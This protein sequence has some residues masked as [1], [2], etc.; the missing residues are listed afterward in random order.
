MYVPFSLN[1]FCISVGRENV[2]GKRKQSETRTK[3]R[4]LTLTISHNIVGHCYTHS[5]TK[6]DKEIRIKRR[7][8]THRFTDKI[9]ELWDRQ[10]QR[11]RETW[12]KRRTRTHITCD[13][14]AEHS[15]R[16]WDR[17]RETNTDQETYLYTYNQWQYSS[18]LIQIFCEKERQKRNAKTYMELQW[19]II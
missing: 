14:I 2:R 9:P 10:R 15:L 4:T 13:N 16:H 1:P 6:R 11:E 19:V 8:F 5:E 17:K 12:I 3:R 18:T 7:T